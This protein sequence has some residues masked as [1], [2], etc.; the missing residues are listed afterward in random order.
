MLLVRRLTAVA[1][2]AT[3]VSSAVLLGACGGD[4]TE[5]RAD[6]VLAPIVTA[7]EEGARAVPRADRLACEADRMT[8]QQALDA[9]AMLEGRPPLD[10]SELVPDWLR[11]PSA[12]WDVDGGVVVLAPGSPCA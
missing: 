6:P 8:V 9:F 10:Q 4:A 5:G 2:L 1:T 3:V 11:E 12:W 7:L